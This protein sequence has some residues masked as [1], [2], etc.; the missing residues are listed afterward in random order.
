MWVLIATTAGIEGM[1]VSKTN[2]IF[3]AETLC[4]LNEQKQSDGCGLMTLISLTQIKSRNSASCKQSAALHNTSFMYPVNLNWHHQTS[5]TWNQWTSI[6]KGR[7]WLGQHLP[8]FENEGIVTF[9]FEDLL[10]KREYFKRLFKHLR[11]FKIEIDSVDAVLCFE[12]SDKIWTEMKF[13]NF[14]NSGVLRQNMTESHYKVKKSDTS[15]IFSDMRGICYAAM[16]TYH[17]Y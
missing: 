14:G 4:C 9:G 7:C 16:L 2:F 11:W 1:E 15:I 10:W 13:W 6:A 17:Y 8:T 3:H 12:I 5:L